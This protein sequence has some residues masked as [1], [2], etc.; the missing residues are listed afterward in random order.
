MVRKITKIVSISKWNLKPGRE[1][2][3]YVTQ[4]VYYIYVRYM[5]IY[6]Y[7]H[8]KLYWFTCKVQFK[9]FRNK[10]K[11]A[12]HFIPNW[13]EQSYIHFKGNAMWRSCFQYGER[14]AQTV[15]NGLALFIWPY[16][17]DLSSY[18]STV[19][20]LC[21]LCCLSLHFC[22]EL[23]GRKVQTKKKKK[24]FQGKEVERIWTDF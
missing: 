5:H 12:V 17:G 13:F 9:H 4:Y 24:M 10:Q 21:Y 20:C 15:R 7:K 23:G 22:L 8:C 1:T 6:Q 14:I 18:L 16:N 19:V 2:V 3:G 11:T